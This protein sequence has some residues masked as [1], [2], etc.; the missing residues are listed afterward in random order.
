MGH[1]WA[2]I[3]L[4]LRE[5]HICVVDDEGRPIREVSCP[6]GLHEIREALGE[7]GRDVQLIAVE[8]GSDTHTVRQL[9]EHGLPVALFEARK[10]S[11]FLAIRRNKTDASDARG[12]ADLARLGQKTVSRVHLKSLE[13]Q[14]LRSQL[15]MRHRL[16]KVRVAT[17]SAIRSRLALYG[18]HLKKQYS[19]ELLRERV[20]AHIARLKESDGVD[21]DEDLEPLLD[22][23][24][25]LRRYTKKLDARLEKAAKN[26]PV[27]R[28]LMQVTGVGPICSLSFYSAI[29]DPSRFTRASDVAAYLGLVPRRHQS[30]EVS[31][32]RG[33]T[34]TGNTMTRTH[35]VNAALVFGFKGP[36][37]HLKR[38]ASALRER[39]GT[40]R[41]RVA[42]ARKLSILLLTIWKNG[43]SFQPFPTVETK[44]A[45]NL[46]KATSGPDYDP[47]SADL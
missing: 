7:P 22:V 32:T 8:A 11:R 26:H 40:R 27:C 23:A 36:D 1:L 5:S 15:A 24:E 10:A 39:A 30:G 31:Y 29:E 21:L 2:G 45:D 41:A 38:W 44:G 37:S 4:G 28:R 25:S 14:Q 9:R 6:T 42:L 33:I 13:C 20:A 19:P 47:F 17:E 16:V 46:I 34:K 18:V 35:L 43:T 3:D 12:L